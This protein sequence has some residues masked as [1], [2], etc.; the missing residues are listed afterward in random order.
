MSTQQIFPQALELATMMKEEPSLVETPLIHKGNE[1]I[2]IFVDPNFND[3]SM[4]LKPL[5]IDTLKMAIE[6]LGM[7]AITLRTATVG[8]T[9]KDGKIIPFI[10]PHGSAA[11]GNVVYSINWKNVVAF[12]NWRKGLQNKIPQEDIEAAIYRLSLELSCLL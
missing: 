6:D 5:K 2:G 4:N 10:N 8:L 1:L 9:Y 3:N 12:K 7:G 11:M